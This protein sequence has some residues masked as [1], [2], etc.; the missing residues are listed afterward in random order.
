M[1]R[2]PPP[3]GGR[4]GAAPAGLSSVRGGPPARCLAAPKNQA[5]AICC[6][7]SLP[8]SRL[9]TLPSTRPAPW[10]TCRRPG[11]TCALKDGGCAC[12]KRRVLMAK[13]EQRR[14]QASTHTRPAGPRFRDK[15]KRK[16]EQPPRGRARAA[17][18]GRQ[19]PPTEGRRAPPPA[20]TPCGHSAADGTVSALFGGEGGHGTGGAE[21]A[22]D[23]PSPVCAQGS[24]RSPAPSHSRVWARAAAP[25]KREQK[26]RA[27][28]ST[29]ARPT[30][31]AQHTRDG[32][33]H[34]RP[35]ASSALRVRR[36]TVEKNRPSPI[37]AARK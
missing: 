10:T 12:R 1:S 24:T 14:R 37:E 7:V 32:R 4:S 25:K 18:A 33:P 8:F 29:P 13:G 35:R 30:P 26:A 9:P 16:S 28:P 36:A 34:T 17:V 20:T 31:R 22:K 21:A 3:R 15:K 19:G 11:D 23:K 6:C 27:P 2:P 5:A